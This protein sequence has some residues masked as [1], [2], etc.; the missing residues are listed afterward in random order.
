[1]IDRKLSVIFAILAAT[2]STFSVSSDDK[3]PHPVQ[4]DK[5]GLV[6]SG[7]GAKGI[8][9]VGVIKALEDNDI[10]INYVA[11]TSMGAIV[12]S[13][14]ACGWSP[15]QM[16]DLFTSKKFLYWATGNIDPKY[17]S[18][19]S[20]SDPSPNWVNLNVG[21]KDTNVSIIDQVI[22]KSLIS[23]IP[24]NIEFL[25]LYGPYSQQCNENFDN[26]F[27]PFRCVTSDVYHKHKIVCR[28]GSL[29]DAVR[30][31]MSF[32]LVFRPIER[33]G[34]LV[35][36]GG[37]YDNFPV[38]VMHDDFNPEFMIGVSVSGPD[39]KPTYQSGVYEQLENMII[40][41]NDY[42]LP[43]QWGVKIQVPVLSFGVLDWEKA[44]EIYDIG[45]Q[46]GLSMVDSIK[47][48][49]SV[50]IP[51]ETVNARRREFADKTPNIEFDSVKVSG[52]PHSASRFLEK[53]FTRGRFDQP[54]DLNQ[55]QIAY[56]QS[57]SS[58]K[59]SNLFP[60][61]EFGPDNHNILSLY[62]TPKKH[63]RLGLG[64]WISSSANSQISFS[65][66]YHT[67]SFNS[68]D[69]DLNAWLGQSYM[70][71]QI[72]AKMHV[73]SGNPSYLQLEFVTSRQKYYNSEIL[74]YQNNTPSFITELQVFGRATYAWQMGMLSKGFVSF[75]GGYLD[76][77]FF[78]NNSGDFA[79]MERDKTKYGAM[80]L[81]FGVEGNNLNDLMYPSSGAEWRGNVLLTYE[82]SNFIA[83]DN[84]S[85][86]S[87]DKL[88]PSASL[89]LY[90][91]SFFEL[92]R[93]FSLGVMGNALGTLQ[94]LTRNYTTVLVHSPEF[95]PTP[96]TKN[97]FNPH[98]RSN[99]YVAAGLIPVWTPVGK[100]QLRGDF[101]GYAPIRNLEDRGSANAVY[102]G[103]FK[104]FD[105][106]GEVAAVYNFSFASL[107]IYCNY[108]TYPKS[109]WNFGL[110]LGLLFQAPKLLR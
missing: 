92:H 81:K 19:F 99:N 15:Q 96:S 16:I 97:Y 32:P 102:N 69:F 59:L 17:V 11:G 73:N 48:R 55:A 25:K 5:V 21:F 95:S 100:L 10:P 13:L 12:G 52:L 51:L 53:T 60:Q 29:S 4:Y 27:V 84:S 54:F 104:R 40:Q 45:Y 67:L 101:Y 74:F 93:K 49:L 82:N 66:G 42:D 41:N 94:K 68:F 1:M 58:G 31:S 70:A 105:F 9:H 8:A 87:K 38:D 107:A 57:I 75:G 86:N 89:E 7:G 50:S 109:N 47:S 35:Y 18:Y 34:I 88:R 37:I 22:P 106:I 33:D 76:D 2:L 90:W 28:N 30:E 103:W 108:L 44:Q 64:A 39:S 6:L 72:S 63:W 43:E 80:A 23:P 98:F 24:M 65:I 83:G 46:T 79:G 77:T 110:S 61:I 56:Y 26:L 62:A 91:K 78:P 3:S 36:D 71:G 20:K 14:Y 85:M